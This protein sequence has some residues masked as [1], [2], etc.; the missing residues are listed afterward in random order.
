M[1]KSKGAAEV[2]CRSCGAE[3]PS[4]DVPEDPE[5]IT[6]CEWCG[7]EYP[8]PRAPSASGETPHVEAPGGDRDA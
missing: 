4:K 1:S 7:A 6:H 5:P 8:I 2:R 3:R